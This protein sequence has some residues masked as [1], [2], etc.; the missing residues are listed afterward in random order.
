MTDWV[1]QEKNCTFL[2]YY[3]CYFHSCKT[4]TMKKSPVEITQCLL[5]PKLF[6]KFGGDCRGGFGSND[7]FIHAGNFNNPSTLVSSVIVVDMVTVV[8]SPIDLGIKYT[9][10][11]LVGALMVL[12]LLK[13]K[14]Q[15]LKL[16]KGETLK[17]ETKHWPPGKRG[18]SI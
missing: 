5:Q 15:L 17:S 3:D 6:K 1:C 13:I 7:N 11:E 8:I 14:F 2:S 10:L 16:K 12:T 18:Q 4:T 9:V